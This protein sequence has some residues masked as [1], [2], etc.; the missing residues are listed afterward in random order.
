MLVL[1]WNEI[2]RLGTGSLLASALSYYP[3]H[4]RIKNLGEYVLYCRCKWVKIPQNKGPAA[5]EKEET[6]LFSL[7]SVFKLWTGY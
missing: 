5:S 6:S 7:T 4:S 2:T 1:R 3:G